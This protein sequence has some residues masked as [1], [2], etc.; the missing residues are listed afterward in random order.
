MSDTGAAV[1]ALDLWP[2]FRA[3]WSAHAGLPAGEQVA[4]WLQTLGRVCP[5]VHQRYAASM[6]TDGVDWGEDLL[7]HHWPSLSRHLP[8][9]AQ[10]HDRLL[11]LFDPVARRACEALGTDLRPVLVIVPVGYGGWATTYQGQPACDLGLDTIVELGWDEPETLEG[12]IA[13]ELGHLAHYRWRGDNLVYRARGP[14]WDLYDEG[15]AQVCERLVRGAEVYSVARH[16]PRWL[17]WGREHRA[18]LAREFLARAAAGQPLHGFFGS[19]PELSIEGYREMGHFLGQEVV[20]AWVEQEGLHAV[21]VMPEDDATR[22][23]RQTLEGFA[24]DGSAP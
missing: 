22:R 16:Q 20:G 15:F 18:A 6:A 14:L 7:Q 3:F 8:R 23:V 24:R 13:H 19:Y 11:T 4:A 9:M 1:P 12:L 10:T 2:A 21:A 5:E 17:Q